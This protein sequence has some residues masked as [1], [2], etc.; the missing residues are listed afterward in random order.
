M[1]RAG[2]IEIGHVGPS[3]SEELGVLSPQYAIPENTHGSDL[4]LVVVPICST[5]S[6]IPVSTFGET[7][8]GDAASLGGPLGGLDGAGSDPLR[9]EGGL[10]L[11][12]GIKHKHKHKLASATSE[13]F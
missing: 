11:K 13:L 1:D 6:R 5:H 12:L 3:N 8:S 7:I 9:P 2:Q 10:S 4:S